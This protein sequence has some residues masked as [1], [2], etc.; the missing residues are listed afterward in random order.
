MR[1]PKDRLPAKE[2][3]ATRVLTQSTKHAQHAVCFRSSKGAP[4]EA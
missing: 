2:S 4:G 1:F 3:P